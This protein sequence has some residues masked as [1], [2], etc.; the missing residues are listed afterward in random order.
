MKT[1]DWTEI[2]GQKFSVEEARVASDFSEVLFNFGIEDGQLYD[3][4][5]GETLTVGQRLVLAEQAN[6]DEISMMVLLDVEDRLRAIMMNRIQ[7]EKLN[8]NGGI[9]L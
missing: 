1:I 4:F 3:L 6:I 9:I 2:R 5:K 7:E 8:A